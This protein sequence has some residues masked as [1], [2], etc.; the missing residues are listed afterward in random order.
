MKPPRHLACS[1]RVRCKAAASDGNP[2]EWV[3]DAPIDLELMNDESGD[4]EKVNER[5]MA[6]GTLSD[7]YLR[8]PSHEKPCEYFWYP[9]VKPLYLPEECS[10]PQGPFMEVA[11]RGHQG[12]QLALMELGLVWIPPGDAEVEGRVPKAL[13]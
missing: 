2:E 13:A 4:S 1:Q 3:N 11:C 9:F 5:A 10:P 12:L 8:A 7:E 6:K